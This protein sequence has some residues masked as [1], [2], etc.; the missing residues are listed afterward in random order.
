LGD[1]VP[2]AQECR[3]FADE[4][5]QLARTAKT[6]VERK[7]LLEMAKAWLQ[8]AIGLVSDNGSSE[9]QLRWRIAVN[10]AKLPELLRE[11]K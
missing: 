7:Q 2:T 11:R 1:V 10:I 3:K 8:I 4:C 9:G 6:D 5:M